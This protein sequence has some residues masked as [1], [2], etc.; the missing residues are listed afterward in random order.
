MQSFRPLTVDLCHE[1]DD[2]WL[3]LTGELDLSAAP[4]LAASIEYCLHA[5]VNGLALD[6]GAVSF[7]DCT[8]LSTLLVAARRAGAAGM[9]FRVHRPSPMVL[10]MF[11]VTGSVSALLGPSLNQ[12]TVHSFAPPAERPMAYGRE[13]SSGPGGRS[14]AETGV[15]G[16]SARLRAENDQLQE[17]L[18]SR[19]AID[20]SLG[21][22]TVRASCSIEE[23][24]PLLVEISQHSN[25]KLRVVAAALV[26]V[27]RGIPLPAA[28]GHAT[29]QA[30]KQRKGSVQPMPTGRK[31]TP[32]RRTAPGL[33]VP[34]TGAYISTALPDAVPGSPATTPSNSN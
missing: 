26:D 24:W 9:A 23:S 13:L 16:D 11:V 1:Q 27:T 15:E 14:P 12:R 33:T 6:L 25:I 8:G 29:N 3:T 19:T 4:L 20:Q 10:R 30:L 21:I 18:R 22:L 31:T 32:R 17:A 34:T 2:V 28:I 5:P 7:C